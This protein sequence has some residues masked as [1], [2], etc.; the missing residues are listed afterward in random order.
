G[1]GPRRPARPP[2]AGPCPRSRRGSRRRPPRRPRRPRRTRSP[3]CAGT[4]CARSSSWS[5]W[6]TAAPPRSTRA[7]ARRTRAGAAPPPARVPRPPG[8]S[9]PLLPRVEHVHAAEPGGRAPVAHRGHLPR[10]GLAAVHRPVQLP[11]RRPAHGVHRPPEVGGGGLVGHVA[12]L[13]GEPAALDAVEAL[14]GELEVVALHVDRPGLVA[15]DV[16]AAVDAR[17]QLVDGGVPL[18]VR[19]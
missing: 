1:R 5:S 6:P 3:W 15:D 19:L 9:T 17:D 8:P 2:R 14:A 7:R 10:L 4:W 13:P 12:Q 18:G 11:G 16:D